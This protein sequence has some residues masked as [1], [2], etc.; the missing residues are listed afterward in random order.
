MIITHSLYLI[1]YIAA[2]LDGHHHETVKIHKNK[3]IFLFL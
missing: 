2:E 1:Q 3:R